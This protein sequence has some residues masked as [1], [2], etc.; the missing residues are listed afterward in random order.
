MATAKT[1]PATEMTTG[2]IRVSFPQ[3]WEAKS[4]KGGKPKFS[5][6][7]MIPKSDK[8]TISK[9]NGCIEAAKED[10]KVSKWKGVIP[11]ALDLPLH[12]G[13][14]Q[15]AL[16]KKG[17]EFKGVYYLNAKSN[18]DAPPFVFDEAGN[19]VIDQTKFYAGC[20]ARAAIQFFPYAEGGIGVGVGLIG[21][22]KTKD[23]VTF[24]GRPTEEKALGMFDDDEDN[25][26]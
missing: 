6:I 14:E 10:G 8:A 22:K 21:L 11:K 2:E 12:D 5:C 18:A 20:Y 16:G 24:S 25:E 7:L 4:F 9:I 26:I 1:Q 15:F 19:R 13:D 3:L 17:E 23:G